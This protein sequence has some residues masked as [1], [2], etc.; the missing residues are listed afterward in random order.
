MLVSR[1]QLPNK[2]AVCYVELDTQKSKMELRQNLELQAGSF[3]LWEHTVR[4]IYYLV[5]PSRRR[6]DAARILALFSRIFHDPTDLFTLLMLRAA[7]L[8][9][10]LVSILYRAYFYGSAWEGGADIAMSVGRT[11]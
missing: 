11:L 4:R 7:I 5:T 1:Q 2:N 8:N 6:S 3:K 10:R 9:L